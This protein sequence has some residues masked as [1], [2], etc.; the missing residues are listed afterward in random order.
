[1]KYIITLLA[2]FAVGCNWGNSSCSKC[3][4]DAGCCDSGSCGVDDCACVC[5]D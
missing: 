5:K 1:M 4:C 3:S 2:V